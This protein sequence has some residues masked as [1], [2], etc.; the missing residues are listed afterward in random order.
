MSKSMSRIDYLYYSFKNK[1]YLYR[2]WVLTAT[3]VSSLA[4]KK[5]QNVVHRESTYA[6]FID[7]NNEEVII[8]DAPKEG[9]LFNIKEK[10]EV[11][12]G[13]LSNIEKPTITTVGNL[14]FNAC[15]IDYAFGNKLGYLNSKKETDIKNIEKIIAAKFKIGKA[16]AGDT[17]KDSIYTDEYL[18][19]TE[20]MAYLQGFNFSYCVCVTEKLLTV[21]PNNGQLKK[22]IVATV[23]DKIGQPSVLAD[24]YKTLDKNDAEF[25]K[26]DDSNLFING[27]IK[28]ARR[29]MFLIQGGEA[30]LVGGDT[31]DVSTNS[32]AEG[33]EVKKYAA[34]NNVLRAGSLNRGLETQLGGVTTKEI[35]RATSNI[36]IVKGDCG[37]K[38]GRNVL[39]NE[40]NYIRQLSGLSINTKE[41]VKTIKDKEEAGTY[42][43]KFVTRRTPQ[44][45]QAAGEN[46]C[47]VCV[48]T[49][50]TA[51]P[52][53]VSM[54]ITEIGGTI[55]GIFMSMMHAKE[56][57]VHRVN[58]EDIVQ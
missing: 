7:E 2:N 45:C 17:D 42:I 27:K 18:R 41:G 5:L 8:T 44:Y 1:L 43:G 30:G 33:I 15:V 53:G 38:M 13:L 26:D 24:V 39:I 57:K 52:R 9:P 37:T 3:T 49:R 19:F 6:Y 16:P 31:Y 56:L 36:K 32:L 40:T 4:N 11:L 20:G 58:L 25:L 29:K 34:L 50:L 21:P 47:E 55:L 10:V 23:G 14:L 54:A 35:I 22:E 28:V 48:G 46:F 12:F 51:H